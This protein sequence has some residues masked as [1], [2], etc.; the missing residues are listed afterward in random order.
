MI[1]SASDQ[2]LAP[3]A[4]PRRGRSLLSPGR[5]GGTASVR[6]GKAGC[7]V[8]GQSD[9]WPRAASVFQLDLALQVFFPVDLTLRIPHLQDILGF[10]YGR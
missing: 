10:P 6:Q 7:K 1:F 3:R 8:R 2:M 9:R 5:T 4:D